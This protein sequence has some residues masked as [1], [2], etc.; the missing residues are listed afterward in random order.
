MRSW[1]PGGVRSGKLRHAESLLASGPATYVEPAP[2]PTT[3]TGPHGSTLTTLVD[4]PTGGRGRPTTSL[5]CS[6]R[7]A[8]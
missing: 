4:Q 3:P 2:R 8:G 6:R 1:S 7:R 5:P